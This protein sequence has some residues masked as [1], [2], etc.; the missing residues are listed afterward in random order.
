MVYKENVKTKNQR[1][2][3]AAHLNVEYLLTGSMLYA[4]QIGLGDF[5]QR[6]S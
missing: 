2:I 6:T 1:L 4:Y 3:Y 5:S